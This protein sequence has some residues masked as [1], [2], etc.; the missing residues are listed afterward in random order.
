MPFLFILGFA[1]QVLII[2]ILELSIEVVLWRNN[3]LIQK[4]NCFM[5]TG[6]QYLGTLELSVHKR[7]LY[8]M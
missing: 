8:N 1:V 2:V 3:C 7:S 6:I 4:N 5:L